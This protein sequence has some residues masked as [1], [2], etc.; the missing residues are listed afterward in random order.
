MAYANVEFEDPDNGRRY[1]A[2]VGF[3]WTTL[4]FGFFPA[5]LRGHLVGAAV[6]IGA[7]VCTAG[8]SSLAFPSFY[9]KWYLGD[10][11]KKGYRLTSTSVPAAEIERRSDRK[12]VV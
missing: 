7:F 3:S 5:L 10:A 4:F 12:S 2:P 8:L 6:Q 1:V 9:N 11:L